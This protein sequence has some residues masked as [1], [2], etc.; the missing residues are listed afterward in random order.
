MKGVQLDL[1]KPKVVDGIRYG[2]QFQVQSRQYGCF[3]SSAYRT[4]GG[5]LYFLTPKLEPVSI[6]LVDT[7]IFL[8]MLK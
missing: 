7:L 4:E 8:D 3:K 5:L 6:Y 1:T 2:Q